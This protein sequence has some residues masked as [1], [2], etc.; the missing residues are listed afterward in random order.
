M[1]ISII[2]PA[3]V[4]VLCSMPRSPVRM[5]ELRIY[6]LMCGVRYFHVI[7]PEEHTLAMELPLFSLWRDG[8]Q[9]NEMAALRY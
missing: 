7:F 1:L 3:G 8:C 5:K 4:E 6:L 2:H 9:L